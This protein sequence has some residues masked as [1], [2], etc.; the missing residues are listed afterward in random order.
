MAT[1]GYQHDLQEQ[2]N[3]KQHEERERLRRE[4]ELSEKRARILQCLKY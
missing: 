2:A 4:Q 3:R 1:T